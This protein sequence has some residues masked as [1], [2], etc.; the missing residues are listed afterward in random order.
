MWV[1]LNELMHEWVLRVGVLNAT[2]GRS[3]NVDQIEL[4]PT[5]VFGI[6]GTAGDAGWP[7]PGPACHRGDIW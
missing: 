2:G 5:P 1:E 4:S 7:A 6:Q 3:L